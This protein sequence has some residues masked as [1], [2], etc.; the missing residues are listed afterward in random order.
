MQYD[1]NL[2]KLILVLNDTR[3]T[4]AAAKT[5]RVSQPTVSV[6]LKKLREQ[7]DDELFVRDKTQ[8][9]PTP[10]CLKLIDAI[11]GLIEQLNSLY[12]IDKSWAI[13]QAKGEIQLLFPPTMMG[14]L[15]APLIIKLAESAPN[16]TID[17]RCWSEDAIQKLESN[18]AC[19]GVGYLPME[20][21][22]NLVEK[23]LGY[24]KFELIMRRDHPLTESSL[25]QLREYPLC[26]NLIPGYIESSK[27]EM[28]IKKY[29]LNKQ[30]NL[31]SSDMGLMLDVVKQSNFICIASTKCR[32]RLS[33]E[34][35]SEPLPLELFK[36]TFRRPFSLFTHLKN[37][38]D[39]LTQWIH[40]EVEQIINGQLHDDY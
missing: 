11:P 18:I 9:K 34:F 5:L 28:L 2:L 7:F 1:Y 21:N 10:K 20:T 25:D 4:V 23:A 12:T 3:Q 36:D 6:M 19:W 15:A 37:K 14:W 38:H 26:I 29:A 17:C 33:D 39:P 8:L 24:D 27:A 16:L 22:K 35:R 13:E 31:R 40:N 30:I 32:T